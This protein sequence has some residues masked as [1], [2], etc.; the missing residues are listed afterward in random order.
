MWFFV[1]WKIYFILCVFASLREREK[2]NGQRAFKKEDEKNSFFRCV[3]KIQERNYSL[4]SF[5]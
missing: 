3:P 5:F 2:K 4:L 1:R